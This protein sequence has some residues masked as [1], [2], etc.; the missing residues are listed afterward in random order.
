MIKIINKGKEDTQVKDSENEEVTQVQY[1]FINFDCMLKKMQ[2]DKIFDK[3]TK[4]Y[5]DLEFLLD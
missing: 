3:K 1:S 4:N 2:I 5:E